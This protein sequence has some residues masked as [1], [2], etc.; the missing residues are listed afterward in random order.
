MS[1]LD[2]RVAET[3]ARVEQQLRDWCK[4]QVIGATGESNVQACVEALEA[5]GLK[6]HDARLAGVDVTFEVAYPPGWIIGTGRIV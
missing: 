2:A 6:V 4:G 3:V 5:R 1:D